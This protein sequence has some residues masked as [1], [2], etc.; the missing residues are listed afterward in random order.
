MRKTYL[1]LVIFVISV[2][3]WGTWDQFKHAAIS[4]D[5]FV[6]F[7]RKVEPNM[8]FLIDNLEKSQLKNVTFKAIYDPGKDQFVFDY[9]SLDSTGKSPGAINTELTKAHKTYG[10]MAIWKMGGQHYYRLQVDQTI[11]GHENEKTYLYITGESTDIPAIK[12]IR[13]SDIFDKASTMEKDSLLSIN[14]L[15][16]ISERC[17]YRTR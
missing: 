1:L 13:E 16:Q 8:I 10:L 9:P 2:I 3:F 17:W 7:V 15:K 14:G 4:S 12:K 11:A 6:S 5:K